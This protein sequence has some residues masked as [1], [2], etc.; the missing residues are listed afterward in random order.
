ML[1]TTNQLNEQQLKELEQLKAI[2]K[3]ADGSTPNLYTHL[4]AQS[5]T[6]PTT[7]VY[8]EQGQ[9]V[10]FLSVYFFY[11]D[12]VEIALLVHPENRHKGIAKRLL[13]KILPLVLEHNY[14]KLIFSSPA[15]LNDRWL[16][17]L[18]FSYRH[19]EYYMERHDL[20]PLLD[21]RK[22]ITFRTATDTDIPQLCL[23]DEACFHKTHAELEPRFQHILGER[24]YQIVLAFD[25]DQL[26]G[27]AHLRWQVHGATLSDIAVFPEK[28]GHGLGTAL[29]T[30]C[31][32]YALSEGKPDLNLDVETHNQKALNLYTRLGFLTQN[33]CDYWQIEAHQLLKCIK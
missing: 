20:N 7:V 19:S 24:N 1:S 23:L 22:H 27:K 15:H 4:L 17:A 12:A 16:S 5:R 8:Y 25:G 26:I 29:I 21:H 3:K 14:F 10:G 13:K 6:L 28:Q 33:A 11:E 18:G 9:L 32:N 30:Y 31:I 2:S